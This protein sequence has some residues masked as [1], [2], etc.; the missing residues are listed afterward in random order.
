MRHVILGNE[1]DCLYCG[2][3]SGQDREPCLGEKVDEVA[4]LAWLTTQVDDPPQ[5]MFQELLTQIEKLH[6]D[7]NLPGRPIGTD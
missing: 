7:L 4:L 6:S 2:R 1:G 5:G 3:P